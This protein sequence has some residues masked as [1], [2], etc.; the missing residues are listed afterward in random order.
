MRDFMAEK[1]GMFLKGF[2]LFS[3]ISTFACA[4]EIANATQAVDTAGKQRMYTQRMLKDYAMIGM[5]NTYGKPEEDLQKTIGAFEDHMAALLKYTKKAET[6]KSLQTV[7]TLWVPIR[8][9]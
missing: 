3:M 7:Q 2:V 5:G 8:Q 1:K 4:V 6:K 9:I